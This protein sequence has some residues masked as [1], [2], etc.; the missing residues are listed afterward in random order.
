M[1]LPAADAL[2]EPARAQIAGIIAARRDM[3]GALLPILHE[4]QDAVGY[5]PSEVLP[6]IARALNLSR[7]EV[8]GVVTYYHDFRERKAGRHVVRVCRAEACQSVGGEA[9]AAHAERAVG[10]A[11]HET[12][13]N[14]EFTLE[15]VYCLGQCACGP[16]VMIDGKLAGRVTPQRFDALLA[17]CER[18]AEVPA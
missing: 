6:E 7:A 8:H 4:I 2:R 13:A 10:C 1:S 17:A 5:V 11:F 9:L 12:T 16:A 3:P 15:A 14:G 18:S